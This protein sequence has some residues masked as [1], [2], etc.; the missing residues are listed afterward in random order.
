M[1]ADVITAVTEQK[2]WVNSVACDDKE[3]PDGRKKVRLCLNPKDPN[4]N[5]RREHYYT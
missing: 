2:D 3:T 4:K 5:I 1:I